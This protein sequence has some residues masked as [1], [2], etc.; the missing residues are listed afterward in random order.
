[1]VRGARGPRQPG[2]GKQIAGS[3]H[4]R[5]FARRHPEVR[6]ERASKERISKERASKE[7][8]SKGDGRDAAGPR[9]Q[10]QHRKAHGLPSSLAGK[11]GERPTGPARSG[12]PDGRLQYAT[13]ERF[14]IES[15][16]LPQGERA[17]SSAVQNVAVTADEAGMRVD[18]FFEARFP[19]LS[20]SHIQRV[21]RK[22][23][24]RVD[25]K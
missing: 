24:V 2:G 22:G 11:G 20:F 18:R 10:S 4:Q 14:G 25:G 1:M 16:P 23:E 19:G 15:T 12:R 7:R 6:A 13:G 8:I 21:I 5:R 17:N 9:H 3:R